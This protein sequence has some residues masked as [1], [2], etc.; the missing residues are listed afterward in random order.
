METGQFDPYSASLPDAY[1]LKKTS[2]ARFAAAIL[3]V[4]PRPPAGQTRA[5]IAHMARRLRDLTA[6]YR[7]VLCV[8]SLLD[9]PWLREAYVE[10]TPLV[11]EDDAVAETEVFRV[12]PE[13]YIWQ[14]GC[15]AAVGVAA[16]VLP[17]IRAA[18]VNVVDGLRSIG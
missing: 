3:P 9:W 1:A 14:F 13:T 15:A 2:A 7:S 12:A 8:C 6:R 5:R 4:I 11:A 16:A 10:R 18:T 17:S